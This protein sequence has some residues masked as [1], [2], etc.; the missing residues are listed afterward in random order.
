MLSRWLGVLAAAL[1]ALS[2]P[3]T[4][5]SAAPAPWP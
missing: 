2:A 3:V 1:I 5:A 4:V